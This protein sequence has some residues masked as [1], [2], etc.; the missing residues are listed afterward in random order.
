[1]RNGCV[2]EFLLECD[3]RDALGVTQPELY[4]WQMAEDEPDLAWEG[5]A[6]ER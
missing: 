4:S 1:L 3:L 5:P 6:R 2:Q